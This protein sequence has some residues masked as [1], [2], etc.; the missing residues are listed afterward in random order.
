MLFLRDIVQIFL[1]TTFIM[2]PLGY[3]LYRR[4]HPVFRRWRDRL[5]SPKYLTFEGLWHPRPADNKQVESH[6]EK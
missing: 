1:L 3:F 5:S 4:L 2:L 6:D